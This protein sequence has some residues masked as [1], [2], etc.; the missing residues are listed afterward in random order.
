MLICSTQKMHQINTAIDA[1]EHSSSEF[2]VKASGIKSRYVIE[3]DSL[4]DPMREA[5]NKG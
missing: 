3:K 4:L 1:L 5:S 2:I